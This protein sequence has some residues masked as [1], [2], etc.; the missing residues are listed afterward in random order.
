M[1][2]RL[3]TKGCCAE[4]NKYSLQEIP[5]KDEL[6]NQTLPI[7]TCTRERGCICSYGFIPI[8]TKMGVQ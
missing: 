6:Q 7:L 5:L 2:A 4:C 1:N 3:I 8:D